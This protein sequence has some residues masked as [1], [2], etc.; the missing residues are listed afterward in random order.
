VNLRDALNARISRCAFLFALQHYRGLQHDGY[1]LEWQRCGVLQLAADAD[2]AQRF[3]AII[4]SQEHP[5]DFLEF[6]DA[7]QAARLAG[8]AVRGAGWWFPGGAAVPPAGLGVASL[9]RAGE[10]VR[11]R[12]DARVDRIEREGRA[13]RALDAHG[14]VLGE[15]DTLVL[16]NASDASRLLPEARLAL[17]AVRGQVTYL[18]PDRARRL[19]VI[20]SGSGYAAPLPGG[21]QCIGA[22][23]QHDDL[24][25][26][27]REGDH[28]ENLARVATMMPGFGA[29]IAAAGLAGWT[30]FRTTVPDRL[31]VFGAS[32]IEGVHL[33]TGLGSRGLL[34]APLGAELLACALDDAPLPLARDHAGAISPRRFLS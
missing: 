26:A 16:A 15:A 4:R 11:R 29:G 7:A 13:W 34:W 21:G 12:A 32:A 28:R 17:S 6:V 2:E 20:V 18:P 19:A 31:P 1:N 24:D 27:V 33:A 25:P 5:P 30:G 3:A 14:R 10:R 23:Y 8:H 22:T 9:A